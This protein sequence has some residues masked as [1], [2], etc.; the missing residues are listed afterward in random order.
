MS[1]HFALVLAVIL[2]LSACAPAAAP[3][4]KED[5]TLRIGTLPILDLM[6]AVRADKQGY[7]AIRHHGH[8]RSGPVCRRA[9][10]MMQA[11]D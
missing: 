11:A 2:L 7:F 4:P 10:S 1:K 9:R 8:V 5:P 3:A 6:A